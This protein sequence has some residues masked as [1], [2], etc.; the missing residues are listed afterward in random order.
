MRLEAL[1]ATTGRG[2]LCLFIGPAPSAPRP[3]NSP[4]VTCAPTSPLP[5][6]ALRLSDATRPETSGDDM[7]ALRATKEQERPSSDGEPDSG[8][9]RPG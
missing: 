5:A 8:R 9:A 4:H 1:R 6:T 2:C 7:V 3:R